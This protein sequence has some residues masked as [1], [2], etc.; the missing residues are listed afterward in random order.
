[1]LPSKVMHPHVTFR[2]ASGAIAELLPGDLIG[3]SDRA[4]LCLSEPYISEAHAMVSLRSGELKLLALRGRFSADGKPVSQ[5]TL[6]AGQR[7]VLAS[8]APLVVEDVV[9]PTELLVLQCEGMTP[10][11]LQAVC[12][13]RVG[14]TVELAPGFLPDADATF[15][16]TGAQLHVRVGDEPVRMLAKGSVIEVRGRTFRVG[17]QPLV[18]R[19]HVGTWES[20]EVGSPLHLIVSY[21]TVKIVAGPHRL[22]LD[23][24][25]ARIL[26]ELAAI[27][28]PVAWQEVAKEIW[29]REPIAESTLRDR[30]DT[31]L[32]RLRRKLETARLRTDLVHSTGVGQVELLLGPGDTFEDRM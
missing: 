5:V 2:L 17:A 27:G 16:T 13:L 28:A 18:A 19:S 26:S 9:L 29:G 12:S 15:W 11:V 14:S 32:A 10:W 22:T 30:W 3:R 7:I 21:D 23:G 25:S 31:S 24:I 4:A 6:R 8:R 1:M 20:A